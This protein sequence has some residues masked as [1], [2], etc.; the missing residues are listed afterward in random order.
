MTRASLPKGT[1]ADPEEREL[2]LFY[3]ILYAVFMH[4]LQE[5]PDRRRVIREVRYRMTDV[6]VQ[7]NKRMLQVKR[8]HDKQQDAEET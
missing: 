8:A 2:D 5:H 4:L 7:R 3:N 6:T 1:A